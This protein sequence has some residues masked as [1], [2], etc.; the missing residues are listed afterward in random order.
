MLLWT[1][2]DDAWT[3]KKPRLTVHP[4]RHVPILRKKQKKEENPIQEVY[5]MIMN[6]G[7]G[8]TLMK[9]PEYD[10]QIKSKDEAETYI[11]R[12]YS[13]IHSIVDVGT[14][15]QVIKTHKAIEEHYVPI[16]CGI[17]VLS[18]SKR[19]MNEVICLAEDIDIPI[20]YQDT[21]SM[22]LAEED[23]PKLESAFKQLYGRD[24]NGK[25]MGQFHTDFEL[26]DMKGEKLEGYSE[27]RSVELI[28]CGKKCYL[29]VL[30]AWGRGKKGWGRKR[31]LHIRMKGVPTS[32][33]EHAAHN[34][35][36]WD[37]PERIAGVVDVSM[38][39]LK[40]E[41][42][43]FDLTQ[44]GTEACFDSAKNFTVR[45]RNKFERDVKFL[46]KD[47]LKFGSV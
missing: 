15:K 13:A 34:C 36:E 28:A 37:D 41:T 2:K 44:N 23:V 43:K 39:L 10:V 35:T 11:A 17:E 19:I 4:R 24:L 7:Y 38:E 12:N 9:A 29:D 31:A 30:E 25:E 22:H 1:M 42:V 6:T 33:V 5:K 45:N 14:N 26:K 16:H 8:F 40:G 21:D 3:S 27:P 20:F 47:I 18:W 46:T 32:T